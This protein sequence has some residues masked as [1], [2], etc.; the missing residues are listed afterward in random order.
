MKHVSLYCTAI[1]IFV[2]NT[3]IMAQKKD[4]A[5]FMQHY[6]QGNIY[7]NK[8]KVDSSMI[9]YEKAL[10]W[11]K[12]NPFFDS[13]KHITEL[14]S[15]MGRGYRIQQKPQLAFTALNKALANAN[16]FK[17]N[18]SKRLIFVRTS[19]LHQ[20]IAENNWS[21]SYP[22]VTETEITK[23][24]FP[25]VSIQPFEKD[26]LEIIIAAGTLDGIK[27]SSQSVVVWSRLISKDSSHHNSTSPITSGNIVRITNN[28]TIIR[29][30]KKPNEII[31]T[32]DLIELN[33]LTPVSWNKLI[34]KECIINN[35]LFSSD[36]VNP[37]Y[38]Y[39]YFY[40]YANESLEKEILESM[41]FE[42]K[43]ASATVEKD[44]LNRP[45]L[46]YRYNGGIFSGN[47]MF[48]SAIISKPIHQQLFLQYVEKFPAS[49]MGNNHQF[50]IEYLRWVATESPLYEGS[51]KSY[52]LSIQNPTERNEQINNLNSQIKKYH[53]IEQWLG[54][55]MQYIYEENNDAATAT[56]QL[57]NN[58]TTLTKDTA[59]FGWYE[60]LLAEIEKKNGSVKQA[61]LYLEKANKI[62]EST[63][64]IEG[65]AWAKASFEKWQEPTE[66]KIGT[67]SGHRRSYIV[68]QSPN[69][70]YF[71]T[72]GSDNL[73]KIWNKTTGKEMFTLSKHTA[74]IT[75]L[76]YSPNGKYLVSA[77]ADFS[78]IIWNAYNYTPVISYTTDSIVNV[79]KFSPDSRL[80]YAAEGA[81]LNIINPFVDS[82]KIEKKITL[83]NG[84]I[85]DFEFYR[86]N[87][88]IILSC[89][90]DGS[91]YA[92]NLK[93]EVKTNTYKNKGISQSIKI[94]NDGR[95]FAVVADNATIKIWDAYLGEVITTQPVFLEVNNYGNK[96]PAMYAAHSFSKDSKY[97][98]Y[99][100]AKDTFII[101]N[102]W[103]IYVRKYKIRLTDDAN[104]RH[105]LFSNDGKDLVVTSSGYNVHLMNMREY[106]FYQ[107]YQLNDKKIN[108]FSN[109]IYSLQYTKDDKGLWYY[110][111]G[112]ELGKIDLTTGGGNYSK[113]IN[114]L[115]IRLETK[116][117][118][119]QGDS[120]I[121]F[122]LDGYGRF[123]T[124]YN[125]YQDSI[126]NENIITLP[127][128]ETVYSF[129]TTKDNTVC[130][131]S[132]N[133][134][135]ILGWDLINHKKIF[136]TKLETDGKINTMLL[137]YDNY[138]NRLFTKA[139]TNK[140]VA[141]NPSNGNIIDS[142]AVSGAR[143]IIASPNT[144]YVTTNNGLLTKF[145]AKTLAFINEQY[146]NNGEV[147]AENMLLT[148]DNK[149]LIVQNT[150]RSI[151]GIDVQKDS[152]LYNKTD[153][154]F[155]SWSIAMTHNG[156]EFATAG[157]DGKI[158]LY[159]TA[160]GKRKA[161]IYIPFKKDPFIVDNENHYLASKNTL[162][163]V[164][165]YYN[166]NVYNYDQFDVQLN[167]PDLVLQNLGRA[168]TAVTKSYYNAYKKRM[169]RL[170]LKESNEPI[171]TNLPTIKLIDK[172]AIETSTTAKEYIVN[173]ECADKIYPL[174]TLQVV[175]N[176]SP[177][178]GV[179]GKDLSKLNTKQIQQQVTIPLA[180]GTNVVKVYCTNAK[181]VSSLKESF[182]V[183]STQKNVDSAK[184]YFIG[185]G[186]ANYK[187]SSMNL[188]YSVKDIRDLADDF[189]KYYNNIVIDTLINEKVTVEN[190]YKLKNKLLKTSPNDR[191]IIA[192][193]GHGLLS[194]SLNFYYA[195]Y[196]VNFAKP[197]LKGLPY[198]SLEALLNDVPAQEKIL[199][200]DACHSGALDKDEL[201]AIQQKKKIQLVAKTNQQ[202]KVTGIA[203][204]SSIK[205]S[206]KKKAVSANSSFELMQNLFSDLSNSNGAIII[207]AAGGMEYAFESAQWN[208][209][210]FT[211]SIREAIFK[212]YADKYY[213][214]NNDGKV[215]VTE[216]SSYVNKRVVELTNGKQKPTSRRENIEFNWTIKF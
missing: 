84:A 17:H 31:L 7:S 210:V 129:E 66:I 199:L 61:N 70:Q 142:F 145:N 134:G 213:N 101:K 6:R 123:L 51:I 89:G 95:F 182:T 162:E 139:N 54:N 177:I 209:G 86:N 194:D 93:K 149:Y 106:N 124:V 191:V 107:N 58:V 52:L 169:K 144:I 110:Q 68:A 62:F 158:H 159:E 146:V 164:N 21:F 96:Y 5:Y 126:K 140:V 72:G 179:N 131:I 15:I 202:D 132:T 160:S 181:G 13:S 67:Q 186:V 204:R 151:M 69:P 147:A 138:H 10:E 63:N 92:W 153:H 87:K 32:K 23:V 24:F 166:N 8:G 206:N 109:I 79:A 43:E 119:L 172:F 36:A 103:D 82:L 98:A 122:K 1:L 196:D 37:Y 174:K 41:L 187:D 176:N 184:T 212:E 38:N 77:G 205:V 18:E 76:Q 88:D 163:A 127:E 30:A 85:L 211:F 47:N 125:V 170:G 197:E 28:N 116:H 148:P 11:S 34:L 137:Y 152:I 48:R 83:H 167:R 201:L 12:Q 35:I 203:S 192:V 14:L 214:G 105:T 39:R 117:I 180:H 102:L 53:L 97:L 33:A 73:I 25:I 130:F 45:N 111:Y 178:L 193:T 20:A 189:T 133:N 91:I 100:L 3:A 78:V 112:P 156:S 50:S 198:E 188:T 29:I 120:S 121:V 171:V 22:T 155:Y 185:I 165:I 168:D 114:Q 55:A 173:I 99:P 59:N 215:S 71:A 44:T 49:W 46:A 19:L 80:L 40:Y 56:A 161:V 104:I 42:A 143:Q 200:I 108:F 136:L 128:N 135:Y 175:V 57:I 27:D 94:S 81:V 9:F 65:K 118:L 216:L 115:D 26:S 195:T 2:L 60:Y 16:T 75:S 190:I 150:S 154:N 183:L 90:S 64:N 4:T 113:R 208:N 157:A 207:S 141:I 74:T